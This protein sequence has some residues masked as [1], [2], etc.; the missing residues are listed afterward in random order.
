MARPTRIGRPRRWPPPLFFT[1]IAVGLRPID[2]HPT[3]A[4]PPWT[5]HA[6]GPYRDVKC[7]LA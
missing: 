7:A 3:P 1:L 6:A 5:L 4:C 2:R